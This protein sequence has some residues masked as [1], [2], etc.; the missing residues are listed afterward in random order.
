MF[1]ALKRLAEGF[2][3]DVPGTP[4]EALGQ[5][6]K[7]VPAY[8]PA[9]DMLVGEG[10]RLDV[11]PSGKGQYSPVH[12]APTVDG[13]RIVAA[14][15]LYTAAD[16]AA[17]RHPEAERL[18]RYDRIQVSEEDAANLG[19]EDGQEIELSDGQTTIRAQATVTDRVKAGSVFVSTLLQGGI[20]SQLLQDDG[21][22]A[23]AR[24]GVL[25]PA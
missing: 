1:V 6:A 9:W 5:I 8:T 13:L 2:E 15:D 23:P 24:I 11:P 18:H 4:D 17:L 14:R 7:A 16:A 20:V 12:A 19:I 21:T 10:V 25:S 3:L 22:F